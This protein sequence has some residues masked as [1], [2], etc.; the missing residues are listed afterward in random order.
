[1]SAY[2]DANVCLSYVNDDPDR[3][4]IIEAVFEDAQQTGLVLYTSELSIVE[5]AFAAAEQQ[6]QV[7]SPE[8]EERIQA[9]WLPGSPIRLVEFYRLIGDDARSLIRLA[10]SKQWRLKPMDAIHLATARRMEVDEFYTYDQ[11]LFKFDAEI[12]LKVCEPY[13]SRPRLI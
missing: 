1:M 6:S 11:R 13:T 4:P 10:I 12:G 5:V 7:L 2:V 8:S 3:I 9:L